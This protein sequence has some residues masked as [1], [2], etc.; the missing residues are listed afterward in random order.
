MLTGE[1]AAHK[2]PLGG[3]MVWKDPNAGEQHVFGSP[4]KLLKKRQGLSIP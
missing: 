3:Q 1:A 4:D 2:A